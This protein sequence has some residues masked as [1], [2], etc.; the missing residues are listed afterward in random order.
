MDPEQ[1]VT[2]AVPALDEVLTG[3]W[4]GD[5]VVWQ[6]DRLEDY[7]GVAGPFARRALAQGRR[8]VYFRFAPHPPVLEAAPGLV[9]LSPDPRPG[10]DHFSARSTA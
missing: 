2:T 8:T 4:L 10:F 3:L 7:I 9:V 6:V 1:K 5:N